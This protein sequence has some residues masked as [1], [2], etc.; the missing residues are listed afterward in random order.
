MKLKPNQRFLLLFTVFIVLGWAL[1]AVPPVDQHVI[2]PFTEWITRV[3]GA[4]LGILGQDVRV[5]GT[6]ILSS[7]FAVNVQNG[8]NGIETVLLIV[9]A[10]AAYPA[11]LMSRISGI[12][13]GT[14]LI[15]LINFVR[16]VTLFLVGRYF[17]NVFQLFHTAVWQ[18]LVVLAGV[19]IFLVWSY[20]FAASPN[21]E[22]GS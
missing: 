20:K 5:D 11:G 21:V 22:A 1:I 19:L 18:I 6:L 2:V 16:I 7:D 4:I 14:V 17:Q 12:V 3:S 15:Q 10:M 9:A 8:C 13:A